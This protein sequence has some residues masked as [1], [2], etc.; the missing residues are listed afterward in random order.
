[1]KTK[2]VAEEQKAQFF[3]FD[4]DT[5]AESNCEGRRRIEDLVEM[6]NCKEE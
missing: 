4:L 1:V 6:S 3:A 2:Q 5:D